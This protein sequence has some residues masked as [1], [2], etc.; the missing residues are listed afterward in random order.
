MLEYDLTTKRGPEDVMG[1]IASE[2]TLNQ[3]RISFDTPEDAISYADKM[4][5]SYTIGTKHV[6]KIKGRT[7]LDNFKDRKSVV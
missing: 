1:W 5:W 6:R 3:V 2:D 4:G 7:Y